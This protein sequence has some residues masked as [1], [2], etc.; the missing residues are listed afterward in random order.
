M[1]AR[2]RPRSRTTA[3]AAWPSSRTTT[4]RPAISPAPTN[5][6][7]NGSGVPTQSLALRLDGD[8]RRPDHVAL[9]AAWPPCLGRRHG[10]PPRVHQARRIDV[11]D[12]ELLLPAQKGPISCCTTPSNGFDYSGTTNLTLQV[13]DEFG[14]IVS[15]GNGDS[16]SFLQGD[17][18]VGLQG[19]VN[20][21]FEDPVVALS[22]PQAYQYPG[23]FPPLTGWAVTSG[24]VDLTQPDVWNAADG[25]QSIDLDGFAA[26]EPCARRCR[27]SP[28][29][30][31][32][33]HSS[34]RPIPVMATTGHRPSSAS[35]DVKAGTTTLGSLYPCLW[36]GAACRPSRR[37]CCRT[38]AGRPPSRQSDPRTN[39]DFVSTDAPSSAFGIVLDAVSVVP[40]FPA[41]GGVATDF[42]FGT[43]TPSPL[44]VHPGSDATSVVPLTVDRDTCGRR[45]DRFRRTRR[46]GRDREPRVDLGR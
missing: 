15:G 38:T 42:A 2:P 26:G 34:T 45:V 12:T 18:Q 8:D 20:G 29:S 30:S 25:N 17:L 40:V 32:R 37:P 7:G 1:Q 11:Q 31:T 6:N 14:F 10:R 23:P 19:V 44:I 9:A 24:S 13:G 43:P 21:S 33:S 3:P 5:G 41:A 35:M 36:P 27:P 4:W 22:G 16:N 28:D 46:T 39:L